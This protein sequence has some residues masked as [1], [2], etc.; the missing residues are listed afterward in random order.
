MSEI[1][2]KELMEVLRE[3]NQRLTTELS[4]ERQLSDYMQ[5]VNTIQSNDKSVN[6]NSTK[7]SDETNQVI[8]NA[9]TSPMGQ[10]CS[11]GSA[12]PILPA[13]IAGQ[14]SDQLVTDSE[15]D[16]MDNIIESNVISIG[17][18]NQIDENSES[19]EPM[20][21]DTSVDNTTTLTD[22]TE[23]TDIIMDSNTI[24]NGDTD[25]DK[26]QILP[27]ISDEQTSHQFVAAFQTYGD[28]IEPN[29][30]IDLNPTESVD[31]NTYPLVSVTDCGGAEERSPI[32]TETQVMDIQSATQE[33]NDI[34]DDDNDMPAV[35]KQVIQVFGPLGHD[36]SVRVCPVYSCGQYFPGIYELRVHTQRHHP[37]VV[38]EPAL[39]RF[40]CPAVGC[41]KLLSSKV[42]LNAHIETA[43][44]GPTVKRS[45]VPKLY[46]CP[47]RECRS[48]GYSSLPNLKQHMKKCHTSSSAV[49]SMV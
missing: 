9:K 7:T 20:F 15:T 37:D 17:S 22:I 38:P 23:D 2:A 4:I 18:I 25:S 33:I 1:V 12:Q 27:A 45:G 39:K 47:V 30:V 40:P 34:L 28:T 21:A 13:I 3:D 49:H 46:P 44:T 36:G 8:I 19:I 48:R 41:G 43:H 24:L 32:D 35:D 11:T 10:L 16:S 29:L 6:E 5:N 26:Q 42:N 14:T 31:Q